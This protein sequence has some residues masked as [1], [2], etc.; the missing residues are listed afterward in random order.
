MPG[1]PGARLNLKTRVVVDLELG[2]QG[3]IQDILDQDDLVLDEG[4]ENLV[5]AVLVLG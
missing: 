5:G 1:D 4:V 2:T 3:Q